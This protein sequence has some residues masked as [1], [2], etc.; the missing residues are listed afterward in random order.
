MFTPQPVNVEGMMKRTLATAA[1]AFS[2]VA[3]GC[4]D[5]PADP[6]TDSGA[7]GAGGARA[8]GAGGTSSG[9]SGG[10]AGG[11]AGGASSGGSGGSASGGSG[12]G[13]AGGTGGADASG[14]AGDASETGDL[15]DATPEVKLDT[16]NLDVGSGG[17]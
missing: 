2:L 1:L 8:G 10:G 6:K 15:R 9:G 16:G 4:D 13:G 11:G 17:N 3:F 5:D 14:E 12:G 7:G